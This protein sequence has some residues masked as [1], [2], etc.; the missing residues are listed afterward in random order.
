MNQA[1]TWDSSIR[2]FLERAGSADPTPGGGSVAALVAAL[3]AAM[4][5][6]VGNLSQGEKFAGIREQIELTLN[7]MNS[8][9]ALCEE[10]LADDIRTFGQYMEALRLPKGTEEEQ[11]N[12]R[13]ALREAT[14]AAIEVPLRLLR[15]CRDGMRIAAAIAETSN[16]NVIS[17]LGIGAILFEAAAQSAY[18][19]IEINLA[20]VKDAERKGE[21]AERSSQLLLESG[22][23]KESTMHTVRQRIAG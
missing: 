18:L 23:L 13:Q 5:S 7:E 3:G 4:T 10:L 6:M 2:S 22:Q 19:T 16:K 21:Y 1:I 17:D 15:V 12:R 9:S 20:S 14:Y 11:A 8:L